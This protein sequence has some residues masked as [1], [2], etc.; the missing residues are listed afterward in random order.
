M[1]L[2]LDG[3]VAIVAGAG[4]GIGAAIAMALAREGVAVGL[5]SRSQPQLDAVAGRVEVEGGRAV[6]VAADVRDALSVEHAIGVV[7]RDLGAPT[8]FVWCVAAMF[9]HARLPFVEDGEIEAMV[10]G[11]LTSAL[12]FVRR[13][14]PGMMKERY[15][16][17]VLL[18]ST[19]ASMGIPGGATYGVTKAGLEALARGLSVDHARHGIAANAIRLGFVD[20]ERLRIRHPDPAELAAHTP[21][22]RIAD[23][24]HVAALVAYLCSPIARSVVGTV[25][26]MDDGLHLAPV[27]AR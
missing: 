20:T 14:V 5:V 8:L 9:T 6:A 2:E 18:S 21:T 27:V 25:I 4:R 22:R 24:D 16:R 10:D 12:R 3:R 17:V 26:E 1:K 19:A 15:G 11:D 7:Q 13:L 23:P